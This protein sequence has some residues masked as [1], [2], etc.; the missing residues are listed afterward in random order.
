MKLNIKQ[1]GV[2]P[3]IIIKS[4]YNVY[5]KL[6]KTCFIDNDGLLVTCIS[7]LYFNEMIK[8]IIII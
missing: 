8:L 5:T 4:E 2:Y 1:S 3:T 6:N 7:K